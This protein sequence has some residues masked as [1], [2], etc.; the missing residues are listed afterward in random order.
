[1]AGADTRTFTP[2]HTKCAFVLESSIVTPRPVKPSSQHQQIEPRAVPACAPPKYEPE[3]PAV[4]VKARQSG[5]L[6]R[7]QEIG[8]TKKLAV[9]RIEM[10]PKGTH[11]SLHSLWSLEKIPM[12]TPC[13]RCILGIATQ[14]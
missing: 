5:Q 8:L 13:F 9:R 3:D 7:E 12:L 1:M 4:A 11:Y 10:V 2:P 6:R 14:I